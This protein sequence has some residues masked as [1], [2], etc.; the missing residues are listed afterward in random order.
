M[1]KIVYLLLLVLFVT[2]CGCSNKKEEKEKVNNEN[3]EINDINTADLKLIDFVVMYKNNISSI[4]YEVV[5]DKDEAVDYKTIDCAIYDAN[6]TLL[7]SLENEVGIIEPLSSKQIK[8]NVSS[9]LRKASSIECSR[10]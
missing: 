7:F 4:Y 1:K 9:D 6:G 8:A 3:T 10:K 5:N 2:G